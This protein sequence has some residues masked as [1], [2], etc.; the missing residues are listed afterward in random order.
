VTGTDKEGRRKGGQCQSRMTIRYILI[1]FPR[2]PAA[3]LDWAEGQQRGQQ[4]SAGC[5]VSW[6]PYSHRSPSPTTPPLSHPH[7]LS[8]QPDVSTMTLFSRSP[9]YTSE[10]IVQFRHHLDHARNNAW[11]TELPSDGAP[12]CIRL[13]ATGSHRLR[14]YGRIFLSR[15]I[16]MSLRK[17]YRTVRPP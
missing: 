4:R 1:I 14:M 7:V 16:L 15:A 6:P 9:H 5:A 12:R 13:F 8:V 10:T 11:W 3:F 17:I 2:I